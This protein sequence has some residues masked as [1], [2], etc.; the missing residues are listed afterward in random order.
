M[1]DAASKFRKIRVLAGGLLTPSLTRRPRPGLSYQAVFRRDGANCPRKEALSDVIKE[2]IDE[3][4]PIEPSGTRSG[5]QR[6]GAA[7]RL[8]LGKRT[9]IQAAA[10]E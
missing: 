10:L 7:C 1:H 3:T 4:G 9:A 8:D 5:N 2:S 6:P